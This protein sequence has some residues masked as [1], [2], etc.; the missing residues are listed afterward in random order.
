MKG[1]NKM[2]DHLLISKNIH[3]ILNISDMT[4]WRWL[5]DPKME[6]P[7]PIYIRSRRYWKESEINNWLENRQKESINGTSKFKSYA[8]P[9]SI[10]Q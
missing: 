7:Q 3:K 4:L 6:F 2:T 8:R 9:A 1:N 5:N 10:T